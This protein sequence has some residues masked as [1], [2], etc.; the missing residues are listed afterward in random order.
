MEAKPEAETG[1]K[2]SAEP[3]RVPP[4]PDQEQKAVSLMVEYMTLKSTKEVQEVL[5]QELQPSRL[6]FSPIVAGWI[7]AACEKKE[8]D[9]ETFKVNLL[10]S[11]YLH[12]TLYVFKIFVTAFCALVWAKAWSFTFS[13]A[14]GIACCMATAQRQSVIV[15]GGS[16]Q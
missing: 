3:G 4:K 7:S 9:R 16:R 10:A 2:P 11:E 13:S 12:K 8:V 6:D 1:H 15:I 5:S 14:F